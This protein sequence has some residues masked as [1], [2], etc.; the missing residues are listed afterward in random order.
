MAKTTEPKTGG[1]DQAPP[2][3]LDAPAKEA[4]TL[5]VTG[6]FIHTPGPHGYLIGVAAGEKVVLEMENAKHLLEQGIVK[7]EK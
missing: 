2:D 1:A 4:Q 5:P 3:I 7:K 6:S